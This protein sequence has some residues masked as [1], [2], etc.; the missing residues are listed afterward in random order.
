[1]TVTETTTTTPDRRAGTARQADEA[2][3]AVIAEIDA[4]WAENDAYAL[5]RPYAADATA[6][7]PGTRLAGRD[8]IRS[9]LVAAF[10]GP[11]KGTRVAHEILAVRP[12]GI[13]TAIATSL[14][15]VSG[16]G[17]HQ[18]RPATVDTWVMTTLGDPDGR[19]QV[20]S[21]HSCAEE[22]R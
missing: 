21:V 22:N 6:V 7:L 15:R 10:A 19:W 20:L 9:V 4:A 1:M 12:I 16:P 17:P 8:Q 2:V 3:R 5:V 11:L 14:A 18:Q 13:G